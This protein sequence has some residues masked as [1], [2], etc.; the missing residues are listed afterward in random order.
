MGWA[1]ALRPRQHPA[2]AV[3]PMREAMSGVDGDLVG[4]IEAHPRA[5]LAA[6]QRR[7]F[8]P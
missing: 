4:R 2:P 3:S 8:E 1:I 7:T 5:Q 6:I